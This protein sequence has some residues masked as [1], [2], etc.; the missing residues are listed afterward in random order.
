MSRIGKKPVPL[1][2]GVTVESVDDGI[3]VKGPK[4]TLFESIPALIRVEVADGNVTFHRP[5]DRKESRALH[6]LA[7]ALIA[8]MVKGDPNCFEAYMGEVVFESI[9][10]NVKYQG[11]ERHAD[12][13][14]WSGSVANGSAR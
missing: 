11:K 6:G 12:G 10:W 1:L 2:D 14:A 4:G 5:D 8:N 9:G 13:S 3:R 7:R